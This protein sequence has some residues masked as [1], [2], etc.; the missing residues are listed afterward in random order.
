[1]GK[2]QEMKSKLGSL[3]VSLNFLKLTTAASVVAVLLASIPAAMSQTNILVSKF[4][5]GVLSYGVGGA[6]DGS[7]YGTFT[8]GSPGGGYYHMVM[9]ADRTGD[10][11]RDLYVST[12]ST[13]I[14]ISDGTNGVYATSITGVSANPYMGVDPSNGDLY[15]V[16]YQ[17]A[18]IGRRDA[19]GA[20][21]PGIGQTG[22]TFLPVTGFFSDSSNYTFA[23]TV[24]P[25]LNVYYGV[26]RVLTNT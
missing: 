20:P 11:K 3:L 4:N 17:A 12:G 26:N 5:G 2:Q 10:G 24:G 6:S 25:D 21:K 19:S 8:S 13:S 18:R 9:G 16:A 15:Y 22:D 23:V 1:M 7:S 14:N